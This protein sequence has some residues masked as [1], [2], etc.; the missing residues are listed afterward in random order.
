MGI[1]LLESEEVLRVEAPAQ[2]AVHRDGIHQCRSEHRRRGC[3][4]AV[5][6]LAF[7]CAD[8]ESRSVPEH[9]DPLGHRF[10]CGDGWDCRL[11]HQERGTR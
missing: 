11:V 7:D 4:D 2:T 9:G 10:A 8:R 3:G 5:T 1:E 6:A